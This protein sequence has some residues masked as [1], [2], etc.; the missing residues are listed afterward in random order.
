VRAILDT[1]LADTVKARL[2]GPDGGSMRLAPAD[3][4]GLRAQE[5]L[6]DVTAAFQAG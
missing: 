6:Y 4:R 1:Q 3:G 2:V 5:R